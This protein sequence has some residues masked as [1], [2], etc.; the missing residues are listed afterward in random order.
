MKKR[1][2]ETKKMRMRKFII[3]GILITSGAVFI[4]NAIWMAGVSTYNYLFKWEFASADTVTISIPKRA[5][6]KPTMKIEAYE[7]VREYNATVTAY[8]AGIAA[9]TDSSPC[10]TANGENICT[11]LA[12]GLK[13]CAANNLKF[14]TR[15]FVEGYGECIVTDRM[16]SRYQNGEI[17]VAFKSDQIKEAKKFGAKKRL[18][19]ILK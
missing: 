12:L 5:I 4:A 6:S 2:Y 14:G 16:N 11:A 15:L 17:D 19:K 10:I 1:K 9:Q 3:K 8:N 7:I 18:I 13:R